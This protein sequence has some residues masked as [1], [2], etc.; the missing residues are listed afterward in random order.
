MAIP[1]RAFP[2]LFFAP[3]LGVSRR[4]SDC[5]VV[6]QQPCIHHLTSEPL[7]GT[8]NKRDRPRFAIARY[9]AAAHDRDPCRRLIRVPNWH[10]ASSLVQYRKVSENQ[11]NQRGPK[12]ET[13][14]GQNQ[15]AR[16]ASVA[17]AGRFSTR[18]RSSVYKDREYPCTL[19]L[20]RECG[21]DVNSPILLNVLR[22]Y[23]MFCSDMFQ[24]QTCYSV[25]RFV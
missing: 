4:K 23:Q 10:G 12:D 24:Y 18:G 7:Y 16:T 3:A 5:C 11:V 13:F 14:G 9:V 20:N 21:R 15:K 25:V 19:L 6:V 22:V 1:T 8:G 17:V 2:S